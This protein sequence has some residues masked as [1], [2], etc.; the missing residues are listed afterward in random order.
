MMMRSY[1]VSPYQ[2]ISIL[3]K[4]SLTT[5]SGSSGVEGASP[6]VEAVAWRRRKRW[7]LVWV[8]LFV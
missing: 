2:T 7:S 1:G 4:H 8:D 5:V 3:E 6:L